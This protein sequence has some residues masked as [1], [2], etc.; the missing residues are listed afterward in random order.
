MK[1]ILTSLD[2]GYT[3]RYQIFYIIDEWEQVPLY[4]L[5]AASRWQCESGRRHNWEWAREM[6]S[7][8]E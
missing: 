7:E 8:S 4:H 2:I 6:R 1:N 5:L 3:M